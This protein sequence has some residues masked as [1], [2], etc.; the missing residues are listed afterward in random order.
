LKT[1]PSYG[2]TIKM[3]SICADVSLQPNSSF[4][5]TDVEVTGMEKTDRVIEIGASKV[6]N[7]KVVQRFRSLICPSNDYDTAIHHLF[8]FTVDDLK[9]APPI[10]NVLKAF[11]QFVGSDLLLINNAPFDVHYLNSE[12]EILNFEMNNQ[13]MDLCS[14]LKMPR[15]RS[16]AKYATALNLP[17]PK[18]FSVRDSIVFTE[19]ILLKLGIIS[20]RLIGTDYKDSEVPI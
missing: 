9:V 3:L 14:V 16:L 20:E 12:F 6:S 1:N 19:E 8:D 4:T 10:I 5:I 11:K 17:A 7:G 15:P 2:V 13:V 18:S